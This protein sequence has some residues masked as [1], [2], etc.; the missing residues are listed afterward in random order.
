MSIDAKTVKELREKTGCGFMDCK[1]A[2]S[3]SKGDIEAAVDFGALFD[4]QRIV[5]HIAFD[6][7]RFEHHELTNGNR[8]AD[9]AGKGEG[10]LLVAS[11]TAW[12]GRQHHGRLAAP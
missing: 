10:Q 8:A 12:V 1:A 2:L 5:M 3:E 4:R 9:P 11:A 7:G 6:P